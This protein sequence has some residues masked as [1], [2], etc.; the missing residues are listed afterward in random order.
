MM[1]EPIPIDA[2]LL[3]PLR[4]ALAGRAGVWPPL[5]GDEARALAQHGVAPLVYS[6]ARVPELR[7]DAIHAAALEPLRLDDLRA[8]LA[9]LE[10]C[11][12][13]PVLMK[14]TPLAYELY[15]MPELR[16][17]G[18]TDLLVPRASLA[19]LREVLRELRFTE[20]LTSGDEHG[21]RQVTFT[22]VDPFGVEHAYDV[23][24]NVSNKAVFAETL[25]YDDVRARAVAVPRIASR[26][27]ALSPVDALFLACIHRVAHHHDSDRLIWLV[28][29]ALLRARMSG[30]EHARF[31]RMAAE[32]RV[33]GVCAR[34]FELADEWCGRTGGARAE[35][36][37]SRDELERDE[38]SRVFLDRGITHGGVLLANFRALPWSARLRRVRQLALPPASFM[39]QNF[40]SRSRLALPWL[41]VY[42]GLRG[43]A[44][45]F[46][47]VRA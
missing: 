4:D 43:L 27:L 34:S 19:A 22:R 26:A 39:R 38:P 33:V 3:A 46:R 40:R 9:A 2:R 37:L 30:E 45:L 24:W 35:E 42:R 20:R 7:S 29:I 12:I 8:V 32:R 13:E 16:P 25:L 21:V 1:N 17:R 6:V 5:T 31:W 18:D 23:H 44:R 47:R 14:G 10:A 15:P 11:G 36:F 41:Y 28:D